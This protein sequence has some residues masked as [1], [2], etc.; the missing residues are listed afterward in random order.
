VLL[1]LD[2][3]YTPAVDVDRAVE[4]CVGGLGAVLE[5]RV[6]AMGTVVAAVRMAQ[7]GPL[8]LFADHLEGEAAIAIYRV[9]DYAA[10]IK[11]LRERGRLAIRE[12]EIPPGPCATFSL[13]GAR[14]GVYELTRPHAGEHLAARASMRGAQP[15]SF[16]GRS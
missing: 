7:A 14:L 15:G 1:S 3:L 5:W 8:V 13:A 10:A 6:A 11:R 12:L 2:F 9:A 16:L 4:R